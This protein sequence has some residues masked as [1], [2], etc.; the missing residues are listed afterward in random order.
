MPLARSCAAR[1]GDSDVDALNVSE[2]FILRPVA[3]T[4]LMAAIL[5][6]GMVAYAFLPLS[7]LPQVD[8]P[9]I[10]VETFYPGASPEVM[11]SSITAPLERQLGQMPGLSQMTS[12]SSAGA[13]IVTLQFS[14]DLGLDVAEQEVQAAIN[15]A[16]NLLPSDL[17]VPP[18]Y[19]KINP[20][21]AP[22]LTLAV[23]SKSL[24]LTDLEDLSETRFAQKISQLTGVGLVTIN[25]G[26]RPAVRIQ[27]KPQ[28]LAAYGL[29][30]D[31]LR[32]TIGNFN[33]NIP[34]GNFDGPAQAS[35]INA[36]DQ[37]QTA[38]QYANTIIA[39]R[40]GNPVRLSDVANVVRGAENDKLGAWA[41]TTPAI[42]L[43]VQRQPGAN[44]IDVV[45]RIEAL[46]PSVR[47]TLPSAVDVGVLSDRT[48]TIRASVADV[49]FELVLAIV[50]V[51]VVIFLFL[52]TIPGTV[53]PSLSVP[54]SL[55]GTL[56]VMYL[57]GF[58]LDNLS[59]MALTIST[60][61]VVDDAIVMIE[62]VARHVE[63]GMN[64]LDA[65]LRGSKEIGFT[66]ISLTISLIAVLIPLLFMGD[67]VGRL[68]H[69]FAITLAVT[70][71]ISAVVSLTLV[72]M[73][74]AKLIRHRP[75]VERS[76]F[77]FHAERAF[78]AIIGLYGHAL[79][80][81][82]ERQ[83]L[84]LAVAALTLAVTIGL[85]VLIPKGFFP[86][87]DT[88]MIQGISEG[89]QSISYEAM[90]KLQNQLAE[91]ILQDPDVESLSSFIGI[92]GTNQ[93]PNAGRFL[94]NLKPLSERK[95]TASEVIRAIQ[96]DVSG[97]VGATLYLQP[98]QDLTI[99]A[100]IARAPLHF[101]LEDVN[102]AEFNTW[103]P[104]IVEKLCT[105]PQLTDVASDLQHEGSTL[106]IVIDRAT[107]ARFGVT[108]ATVDNALYDAFGQR[109]ISTTYTQSNQYR[110]IMEADPSAQKSLDGL[111]KI[112][113]PSSSS[114]TNG[115]VP[116]SAIV[117]LEQGT[118]P[119]LVTHFGQLPATTISFN[120]APGVS[121]GAAVT[122]IEQ[123]EKEVS[124][125]ASFTTAFQGAAAA[126]QSSLT[127]EVFLIIAAVVAMYIVLGVLYESFIHPIT[128][129]STL[130][131]A[132]VGALL[133]LML[134]HYD[135]DV[136]AIIG[137]ILLIGIVKKNAIMMIDFALEAERV[138]GLP[139]REAIY[140]A[141]LLRFRPILMT[142][143]AALLGALPLML[144][145][146]TG[147]E[148][149]RPLGIAIV[150]GLAL[151]Q[152]L[153]LFTTPVIYLYLDRLAVRMRGPRS[154]APLV[155]PE[156]SE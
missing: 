60:G 152:L 141:C 76:G 55:V 137:I 118:G 57:L 126:F 77:D 46:L 17:P 16:N 129:L 134:L 84:T 2:P 83:P 5:L 102:A 18:V 58:S 142:T 27:F 108:P 37:L 35:T 56:G 52:R 135:L 82:L 19:A 68:F 105:L 39:Y 149:R 140:Q 95:R 99:D 69:E 112:Y 92:D 31:D 94:I 48:V 85:Y 143:M 28:A 4:L 96:Q 91:A 36:N 125:P 71:V 22:I 11:T 106:N 146:G 32:T 29:N 87:Q 15:A 107:S 81:V 80:W 26:H 53:I 12:A 25:G 38:E 124:L 66:I 64:P 40:N 131:S 120:T 101:V 104:R 61:F 1:R 115:Q 24:S 45:N 20:A 74:C 147:S 42:I 72:P 21:D 23:T 121:L 138:E 50:L 86:V 63:G 127:N 122:A 155:P 13:S 114:T 44:T 145:S 156:P 62:N 136:I 98:V 34:K 3:T 78:N 130:P 30:I 119:L 10:Q 41:N 116:L 151:S 70:I 93:T 97:V 113:L 111:S 154:A 73:M 139:P 90:A 123:A 51:V 33:V 8:Y 88:G 144:G 14:L 67:V 133:S 153:T 132:A 9:T 128:I 79:R 75:E 117:H 59:L 7:T 148:L 47:A 43:N 100:T 6:S 150:G 54:L 89:S 103:V 110:V 109:I 49:E 65:A